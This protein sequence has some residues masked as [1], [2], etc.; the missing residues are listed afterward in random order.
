MTDSAV[1]PPARRQTLNFATDE[2]AARRDSKAVHAVPQPLIYPRGK[3]TK[4]PAKSI[5]RD[6][7]SGTPAS[8]ARS[9]V[10]VSSHDASKVT[11][12]PRPKSSTPI[13]PT[14][15]SKT[16][17]SFGL[18]SQ[19]TKPMA[20]RATSSAKLPNP[21]NRVHL[22]RTSEIIP[23]SFFAKLFSSKSTYKKRQSDV[24]DIKDVFVIDPELVLPRG[25]FRALDDSFVGLGRKDSFDEELVR[26]EHQPYPGLGLKRSRTFSGAGS[27][28]RANGSHPSTTTANDKKN[29]KLEVEN[30]GI[31]VDVHLVPSLGL[32]LTPA[33]RTTI[34]LRLLPD[35]NFKLGN[36][37]LVA[38]IV[39]P[40][41]HAF[42]FCVRV[43]D[44]ERRS[45]P[46]RN[47]HLFI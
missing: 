44:C 45:M 39:R 47:G 21:T 24:S 7:P 8:G 40:I 2:N 1:A 18:K 10:N 42:F 38:R 15:G 28:S 41:F 5:T 19:A 31:D 32:D 37:P 46:R 22:S 36:H 6:R 30:G 11:V 43:A 14:P 29:L 35:E 27:G 33:K 4:L 26:E 17:A 23:I 9:R 20:V 13:T 3:V 12:T 34:D 25:M 16:T